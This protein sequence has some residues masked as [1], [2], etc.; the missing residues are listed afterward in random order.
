[1]LAP[2]ETAEVSFTWTPAAAGE[3]VLT[4]S[5]DPASTVPDIDRTNNIRTVTVTVTEPG[6]PVADFTA[7]ITSGELPLAVQFTDASTGAAS[8]VWNFGDGATSAEQNPIHVYTAA[9]VYTVNLTVEND[10][11]A[12]SKLAEITVTKPE[13]IVFDASVVVYADEPIVVDNVTY[14][15]STFFNILAAAG[16]TYTYAESDAG[17]T[18]RKPLLT[19]TID[20]VTYPTKDFGPD[21]AWKFYETLGTGDDYKYKKALNGYIKQSGTYYIWFGDTSQ[22]GSWDLPTVDNSI[23]VVELT[24]DLQPT[25]PGAPVAN[26]TANVTAGDAPLAVRFTD[27]STGTTA[28]S[29]NFGDGTT[30]TEQNPVHVYTAAGVYTVSLTATNDA[31]NDTEVK[32]NYITVTAEPGGDAPVANFAA[33]VTNGDAPLTVQFND[34]STNTPTSWAWD[35]NNDDTID[36]TEQNPI[37]VY[38]AA[39]T[40]TV[41]LTATNDAGSDSEVKAGYITVTEPEPDVPVANFTATPTDGEAPLAVQFTD[42]ST[43]AT[44]WSWTFGDGATS[45]EQYPAHIYTAIGRYNVTLTVT[46]IAG[47]DTLTRYRYI[48]VRDVPSEPARNETGYPLHDN[49]TTVTTVGGQQQVTF[50]AT[51]GNGTVSDNDI[52]LST[53]TLNV[54]IQTDGLTEEDGNWTGNVTGVLF[55]SSEPLTAAFDDVGNVS[56]AFNASMNG[57]NPNLTISTAIYDKPSANASTAFTLAAADG[58]LEIT[59]TAYA[60]YFTKTNL[61]ENDTISNATLQ[62]TVSPAWVEA[63]GG[64]V[65]IR[66]FRQGDDGSVSILATTYLGLDGDGMMVF[67]AISPDGF[68]SF[69]VTATKTVATPTQPRTSGGGGSSTATV[70]STGTAKLLTA[71]WGGVLRPYLVYVE[72]KFAHLS[73]ETGVTALD[74]AGSPLSGVGIAPVST[75]P[76]ASSLAFSGYAVDCSPAGAT[77]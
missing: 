55:E 63:N 45:A 31:G 1:P 53:D 56:I 23:Y 39:G 72:G 73:L 71:S 13:P 66:V 65:A 74:D 6:T 11:G 22:F 75:L 76:G 17:Y 27:L 30:S 57:Y 47:S 48:S 4:L 58:N 26:F 29:W 67:E 3:A 54:T 46:N 15:G 77:F 21:Y 5:V 2:G 36:S 7:N 70:T 52:H 51:A 28:R 35:F 33:N 14:G 50:N 60:V 37:H 34:L 16:Y 43:G 64:G 25:R 24:V 9:G 12:S 41:N 18:D 49:G 62:M 40:Y 42:L 20:G 69:A 10:Y 19:L 44:A 59:S 32:T 8:W 38:D 68:S 61:G